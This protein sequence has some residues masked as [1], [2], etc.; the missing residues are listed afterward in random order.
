MRPHGTM[1]GGPD[2]SRNAQVRSSNLLSGSRSEAQLELTWRY[3]HDLDYYREM[4]Q[5]ARRRRP[6]LEERLVAHFNPP[7]AG[8]RE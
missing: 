6:D 4:A 3:P 5:E 2:Q 1:R 8:A 7:S